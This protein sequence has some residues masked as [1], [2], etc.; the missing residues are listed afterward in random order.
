MNQ[1]LKSHGW[2][3]LAVFITLPAAADERRN[4]FGIDDV[5]DPAGPMA[6]QFADSVSM[7]AGDQSHPNARD[8]TEKAVEGNPMFLDG[9]WHGRWNQG[10]GQAWHVGTAK[11]RK[12]GDRVFIL[13]R[14]HGESISYLIEGVRV[15]DNRLVGSYVPVGQA[16]AYPWTGLIVD[17]ERIDGLWNSG[18]RWDF[19][20]KAV[21]AAANKKR[22]K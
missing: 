2:V 19:R 13:Y 11:V 17:G 1:L 22:S 7:E 12:K 9:D 16:T 14:E 4:P 8:W 21:R 3:L 5:P 20:R 6:K 10:D 18:G 15:G